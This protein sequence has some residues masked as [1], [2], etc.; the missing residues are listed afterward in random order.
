MSKF[1]IVGLG[2]IGEEYS[3]TRH[4]IGF[5]VLDAIA[6]KNELRFRTDRLADVAECRFKGKTLI[7]IKPSTYMNLSGK[8][9][10]YWLQAEKIPKENLLII[11]DDIA[12]PLGTLRM[13][14]KG[15]DGGHNGLKNV[16]DVLASQ[17]YARL[18]I[19][20]GNEFA[21]GKQVDYVLGKW[22]PEEEILLQPRIDLAVE[23]I[24]A[25]ATIGLQR[26]MSAYNNK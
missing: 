21:K 13:K 6:K 15:S 18:R 19:G 17:E 2:N 3:N 24:Q 5:L 12:L 7:L 16:Q 9:V 26:T 11:T 8:A 4:N 14:G 23:M 25:F 20:V 10:N 22:K 1:L